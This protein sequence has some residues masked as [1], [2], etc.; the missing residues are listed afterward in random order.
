VLCSL[1]C[2]ACRRRGGITPEDLAG[3][4]QPT[5]C[6]L[7][8]QHFSLLL[9]RASAA[10]PETLLFV[11]RAAAVAAA[12]NGSR[13]GGGSGPDSEGGGSGPGG[14]SG[15]GGGR[16]GIDEFGVPDV[17]AQ[18]LAEA[19]LMVA[20]PAANH[21]AAAVSDLAA[22]GSREASGSGVAAGSGTA[23]VQAAIQHA[24]VA[25]QQLQ[26]QP[27]QEGLRPPQ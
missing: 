1:L 27:Q 4:R 15:G 3:L 24:H 2:C 17:V 6:R 5:W 25:G 12:N 16:G 20:D 8:P 19:A 26:Q 11:N 23:R 18:A 7:L 9:D 21:T 13:Q 10:Y 14:S 22:N